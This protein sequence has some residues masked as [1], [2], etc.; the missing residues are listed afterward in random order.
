MATIF[1]HALAA[2][3]IGRLLSRRS[4]PRTLWIAMAVCACLPDIDVIGF[5]F[6]VRYGDLLGHRGLTHSLL[7][8]VVTGAVAAWLVSDSRTLSLE[9]L[10][11]AALLA[12]ATASHGV[13]DAL[14]DGGLGVAFFSPFDPTRYFFP[15]RPLAVSPIG[16]SAFLTR[17]GGYVLG[18]ELLVVG[19]PC[20]VI[21]VLSLWLGKRGN[22]SSAP[23][24]RRKV[25]R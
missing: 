9:W 3:T 6:G 11:P 16:L 4:H 18:D 15:V 22:P 7:F 17:R 5:A 25:P 8:A 24:I 20:L 1:S 2:V 13:L 14:T 19:L 10:G 12:A 21:L 23:P